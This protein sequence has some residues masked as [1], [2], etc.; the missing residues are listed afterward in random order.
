MLEKT[1]TLYTAKLKASE[2]DFLEVNMSAH[3]GRITIKF[4][5]SRWRTKEETISMLKELIVQIRT[6]PPTDPT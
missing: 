5:D 2:Y 4:M 1:N 6:L 3:D